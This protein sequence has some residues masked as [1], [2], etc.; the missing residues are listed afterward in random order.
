MTDTVLSD[1][2]YSYLLYLLKKSPYMKKRSQLVY[3]LA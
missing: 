1:A 3:N 2:I